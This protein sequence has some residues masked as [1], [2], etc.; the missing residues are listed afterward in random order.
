MKLIKLFPMV[1]LLS[2]LAVSSAL[3]ENGRTPKD[4]VGG[5]ICELSA[6]HAVKKSRPAPQAVPS[7]LS[8]RQEPGSDT[9]SAL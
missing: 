5:A 6:L 4:E 8:A 3:A 9:N 1:A 7:P 2:A